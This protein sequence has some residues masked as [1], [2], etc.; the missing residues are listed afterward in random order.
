MRRIHADLLLLLTALIWGLAFVF[1]KTAMAHIGPLTFLCVR[2]VIAALALA[3]LALREGR[4]SGGGLVPGRLW[5]IAIVAGTLFFLGGALQQIGLVTATVTN[6]GF[7][8]GLYVV[9]VP[10]IG[11][12]LFREHVTRIIWLAV[13]LAFVGTWLLG[14][15]TLAGFTHGDWLVAAGAIFW[16]SHLHAVKR[17][18]HHARPVAFTFAQFVVIAL[19]A[20]AGAISFEHIDAARLWAARGELA[21]VG[22]LSSAL[23]FTL[24]AVA[25]RHTSAAEGTIIVSLETLFAA[26]AAALLLGERLPAI[27]WVGAALMF[28]ASLVVQV[29]GARAEHAARKMANAGTT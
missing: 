28:S 9:L 17:S 18:G 26:F 12:A 15:G 8:T 23:T 10:L 29:A 19:F 25:M 4:Q 27:G 20:G 24:L 5:P 22:L 7:L 6:T 14:G 11:L 2:S 3:P 13:A 21:Y 16:A 1:Q